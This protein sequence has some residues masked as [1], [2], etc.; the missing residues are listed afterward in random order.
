MI[1]GSI[2]AVAVGF[3]EYLSYFVPSLGTANLVLQMPV[4]WGTFS[5]SAGQLVAAAVHVPTAGCGGRCIRRR[6]RERVGE[7]FDVAR[8][9]LSLLSSRFALR[10]GERHRF[11]RL[12]LRSP[13]TP[14]KGIPPTG[15]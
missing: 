14:A 1:S 8:Q 13:V 5:I 9:R 10:A 11:A 6:I 2:A 15:V 7:R 12:L 3:A 4:P